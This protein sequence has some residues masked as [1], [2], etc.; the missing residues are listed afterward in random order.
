MLKILIISLFFTSCFSKA[1]TLEV[2]EQFE[3]LKINGVDQGTSFF[4]KASSLELTTGRQIIQLRY[5]ELFED[6]D[7]DDHT[8][9]TSPPFILVVQQEGKPLFIQ[10]VNVSSLSEA[11]KFA[12][13]PFVNVIDEAGNVMQSESILLEAFQANQYQ[14]LAQQPLEVQPLPQQQQPTVSTTAA[15]QSKQ[16]TPKALEMLHYWWQQASKESQQSFVKY[17][18]DEKGK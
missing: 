10:P 13:R 12:Q 3:V 11:K 14:Q 18:S 1:A 2:P 15:A 9:V 17:I 16:V 6:Y 5:K 4:T 7:N 8:T